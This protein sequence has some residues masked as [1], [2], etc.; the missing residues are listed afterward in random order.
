MNIIIIVSIIVVRVFEKELSISALESRFIHANINDNSP[1]MLVFYTFH[2]DSIVANKCYRLN[3]AASLSK[4]ALVI[5]VFSY[6]SREVREK[7]T[8]HVRHVNHRSVRRVNILV[9]P[10]LFC[11]PSASLYIFHTRLNKPQSLFSPPPPD[12]LMRA[13]ARVT[14]DKRRSKET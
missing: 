3:V 10:S 14:P 6:R 12:T 2:S 8:V 5:R 11:V 1:K 4:R 7:K 9:L 13:R